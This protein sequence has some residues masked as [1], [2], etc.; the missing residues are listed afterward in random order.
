M[1]DSAMYA[2]QNGFCSYK[3]SF[4]KKTNIMQIMTNNI[5]FFI[6]L[7]FYHQET[8]K[9][10]HFELCKRRFVTQPLQNQPFC[11]STANKLEYSNR[12]N[13]PKILALIK[14]FV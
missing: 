11:S 5:T 8:V 4:H 13:R 3:L 2:S 6:Y 12:S 1:V 14:D 7:I 10:D 9:L